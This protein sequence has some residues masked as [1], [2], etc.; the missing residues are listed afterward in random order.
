MN[1]QEFAAWAAT[2]EEYYGK[3]QITKSMA[4]MDLWYE[5]I[6]DLSYDQCRNAARQIMDSQF[7]SFCG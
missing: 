3:N 7:L 4:S 2:L 6:G 5:L 1:R